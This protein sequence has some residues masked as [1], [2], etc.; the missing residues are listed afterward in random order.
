MEIGELIEVAEQTTGVIDTLLTD[1]VM[2]QIGGR[3]LSERLKMERPVIKLLF[4]SGY[5]QDSIV[6]Q[7]VLDEGVAFLHKLFNLGDLVR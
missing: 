3:H 7:G 1:V 4:L 2:P 6:H 5:T